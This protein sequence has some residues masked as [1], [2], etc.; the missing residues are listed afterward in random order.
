MEVNKEIFD[1]GGRVY[2]TYLQALRLMANPP[3][4][5]IENG[6]TSQLYPLNPVQN[7]LPNFLLL[8]PLICQRQL[9]NQL[10]SFTNLANT[11]NPA[12]VSLDNYL[13]AH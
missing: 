7:L 4:Q 2:L 5:L 3:L 6:A 9:Y 12:A 13:I 8:S 11:F 1:G 10:R